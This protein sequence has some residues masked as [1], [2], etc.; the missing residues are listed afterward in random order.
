MSDDHELYKA[1]YL[2]HHHKKSWGWWVHM[3][4]RPSSETITGLGKVRVV[5]VI[6]DN[7]TDYYGD[8]YGSGSTAKAGITFEVEYPDFT[9]RHFRKEGE[10]DS[11]GGVSYDHGDFYEVR[12]VEKV[13][14]DFE[15]IGKE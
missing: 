1:F 8:G 5:D 2:I 11:Y 10:Y 6:E 13:V 14:F 7:R 12:P 3:H 9:T 4:G 15:R